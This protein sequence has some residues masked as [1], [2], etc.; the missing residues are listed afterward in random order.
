MTSVE[1]AT[2]ELN[3][4]LAMMLKHD[5][6]AASEDPSD[7][8][9]LY[10]SAQAEGNEA[11]FREVFQQCKEELRPA[12]KVRKNHQSG[13]TPLQFYFALSHTVENS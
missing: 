3:N 12:R 6:E 2:I 1:L 5:I 9:R 8:E 11:A 4:E 13:S 10:R 7:L